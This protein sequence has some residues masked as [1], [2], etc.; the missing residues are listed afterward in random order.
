VVLH[1]S[2][3][4]APEGGFAWK[5]SFAGRILIKQLAVTTDETQRHLLLKLLADEEAKGT[6]SRKED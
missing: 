6:P 4:G 1:K 3:P 5:N 2:P